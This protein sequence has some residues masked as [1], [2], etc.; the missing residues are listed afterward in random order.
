VE[1][2]RIKSGMEERGSDG[3]REIGF[4]KIYSCT[5]FHVSS[6]THSRFTEGVKIFKNWPLDT[7]HAPCGGFCHRCDGSGTCQDLS[8]HQ[9]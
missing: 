1:Q 6:F 4:A 3:M 8:V 9:I 2:V 5:K 7:D